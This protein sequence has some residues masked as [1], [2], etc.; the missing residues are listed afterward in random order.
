M[1]SF[2]GGG[3]LLLGYS[4]IFGGTYL[5]Y[6]LYNLYGCTPGPGTQVKKALPHVQ[7]L[8]CQFEDVEMP[9]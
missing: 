3:G 5:S 4:L 6:G 1:H 8:W 9:V 7:F 2:P